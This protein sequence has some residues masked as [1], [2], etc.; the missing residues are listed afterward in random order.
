MLVGTTCRAVGIISLLVS[1]LYKRSAIGRRIAQSSN[2]AH[3]PVG[4]GCCD[5]PSFS[6]DELGQCQG[7]RWEPGNLDYS[8]GNKVTRA[9]KSWQAS[10]VLTTDISALSVQLSAFLCTKLISRMQN[11]IGPNLAP[12]R[13]S[14]ETNMKALDHS[15]Q[16]Y[17]QDFG[18]VPAIA[19]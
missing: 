4:R 15:M 12:L 11:A 17:S 3:M 6:M 18:G 9:D 16:E 7:L 1:F 14:L 13:A 2:A 19:I 8:P 5:W 10:V